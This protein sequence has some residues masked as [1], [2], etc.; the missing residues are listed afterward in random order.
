VQT[1]QMGARAAGSSGPADNRKTLRVIATIFLAL[2]TFVGTLTPQGAVVVFE[3][4]NLLDFYAGV[5]SLIT[6]TGAVVFGLIATERITPIRMRVV[7]QAVH[8]SSALVAVGFL[9]VHII[10]KILVG[11]AAPVDA[12]LPFVAESDRTLYVGI[13]T[14]SAYFMV[15]AF[16]VGMLR[17][18]FIPSSRKWMWRLMHCGA[19]IAWP[20]AIVHGL[21]AGRFAAVWVQVSWA[22]CVAIVGIGA[23][24]RL[25]VSMRFANLT[26]AGARQA[27]PRR[28]RPTGRADKYARTRTEE[29]RAE[30][31]RNADPAAQMDPRMMRPQAMDPRMLPPQTMDPRMMPPQMDPRMAQMDPRMARQMDP[32]MAQMDPRMAAQQMRPGPRGRPVRGGPGNAIPDEEFWSKLRSEVG[33]LGGPQ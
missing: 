8:R 23:L 31:Y 2:F 15:L 1:A 14:I 6:L 29:A 17:R 32:R 22:V 13:G 9:V 28:V 30:R 18:R 27:V 24:T 10:L 20:I 16:A 3:L 33:P 12:F 19:Y 25:T 7:A 4:Q 26:L 11:R 5:V 21:T